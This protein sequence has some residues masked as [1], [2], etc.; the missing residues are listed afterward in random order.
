MGQQAFN[1]CMILLLDAIELRQI[2]PGAYIAE[3]AYVVFQGLQN[4]HKLAT[5][6]MERISW[7][8]KELR[9]VTQAQ[10]QPPPTRQDRD[11]DAK[12]QGTGSEATQALR[13]EYENTVMNAT[14]M[15]LLEDPGLQGFVPEAFAPISWNLSEFEAGIPQLK[16]E[17]NPPQ[18]QLVHQAQRQTSRGSDEDIHDVRS[19]GALQGQRRST[20]MRSAHTSYATSSLDDPQPPSVTAP[21]SRT[22]LAKPM[23]QHHHVHATATATNPNFHYGPPPHLRHAQLRDVSR[24]NH[25]FRP[26]SS[27]SD[28]TPLHHPVTFPDQHPNLLA[29]LR[30]NSCPSISVA[31]DPGSML[32]NFSYSSSSS[33]EAEDSKDMKLDPPGSYIAAGQ[34]TYAS[35]LDSVLA[36]TSA[37]NSQNFHPSW[38]DRLSGQVEVSTAS[39]LDYLPTAPIGQALPTMFQPVDQRPQQIY[40]LIPQASG[41]A[42]YAVNPVTENVTLDEWRRWLG[43]SRAG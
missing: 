17:R 41:D 20:A 9:D 1:A 23:Q 21:D 4:V 11:G 22:R 32:S 26:A 24:D 27:V 3:K 5:L 10:T 40:P 16:V 38:A 2:T 15:L 33:P 43:A 34:A 39:S 35:L 31:P 12:M 30:H 7:G 29:Q 8:L 19:A 25:E 36:P 28:K 18:D 6:A 37:E 13:A 14:G 42:A